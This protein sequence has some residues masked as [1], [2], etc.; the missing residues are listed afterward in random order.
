MRGVSEDRRQLGAPTPVPGVRPRRL[1]RRFAESARD[2]ALPGD[3]LGRMK[4]LD[5]RLGNTFL[6]VIGVKDDRSVLPPYVGTLSV[7]GRRVVCDREKDLQDLS[8]AHLRRIEAH[9]DGLGV[10]GATA[11][12]GFVV[13]RVG[14]TPGVA[15]RHGRDSVQLPVDGLDAP[16][17]AA[18]ED[19][20][21][22]VLARGSGVK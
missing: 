7:A 3:D 11:R 15:V 20:R 17:T 4:L 16:K 2:Q 18:G 1:L 22:L 13:R 12:N 6:F 5:V 9:L 21:L 10:V 19:R 8:K 14:R